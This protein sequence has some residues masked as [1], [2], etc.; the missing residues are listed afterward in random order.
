MKS[1]SIL[2][3]PVADL[4]LVANETQ[5]IGIYFNDCDHVPAEKRGWSHNPKMP[6]LVEATKQLREY[7]D[8]KRTEFTLPLHFEGTA[9]Q[10]RVWRE[11][12]AIPYGKTV[13]YSQLA[14]RAGK[15]R[16]IRAAGT[17]TGRNPLA[18]VVPCHRVLTKGGSIGG[19][20]GGLG[21]KRY[22]LELEKINFKDKKR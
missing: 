3:T 16:A 11:I 21:R 18:I 4:M 17:N 14:H 20:A 15:A 9:F 8:G 1:Y 6:V 2:K 5:L 19:Y 12:A 13:S 7:F 10:E 22:L